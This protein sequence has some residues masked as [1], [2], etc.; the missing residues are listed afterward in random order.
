MTKDLPILVLTTTGGIFFPC[1]PQDTG[2][3][4]IYFRPVQGT[5][6]RAEIYAPTNYTFAVA[7]CASEGA[8]VYAPRNA[9]QFRFMQAFA[10]KF[11]KCS[12]VPQKYPYKSDIFF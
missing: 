4:F 7:D 9:G 10:S 5:C 3:F 2:T 12:T 1:N 6:L 8:V 11:S